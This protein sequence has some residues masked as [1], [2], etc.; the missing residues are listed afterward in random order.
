MKYF[1]TGPKKIKDHLNDTTRRVDSLTNYNL[2][3]DGIIE[4]HHLA[5]GQTLRINMVRLAQRLA[6]RGR[7]GGSGG[8]I[9]YCKTSFEDLTAETEVP[10][11]LDA[12]VSPW[13][14]DTTYAADDWCEVSGTEYKSLKNN[15]LGY[16]VTDDS[17]WEEGTVS[18][19]V[20]CN[21]S[22]G[23]YLSD[24]VPWLV[25]GDPVYIIKASGDW[26][27]PT[28]FNGAAVRA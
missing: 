9:A 13:D 16:A 17:W 20:K 25:D 1:N 21:I 3:G 5:Q 26:Y 23:T 19:S 22:N 11:Y 27:I 2:R 28:Q 12:D 14:E 18:V 10:C 15:N 24:V 7:G 8:R 6:V 4:V